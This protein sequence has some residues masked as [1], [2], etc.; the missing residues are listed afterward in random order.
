MPASS[1]APPTTAPPDRYFSDGAFRSAQAERLGQCCGVGRARRAGVAVLR[2]DDEILTA[3]QRIDARFAAS[4]RPRYG[5]FT[6]RRQTDASG[7]GEPRLAE[8]EHMLA[9]QLADGVEHELAEHVPGRVH[10]AY[11]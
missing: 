3:R 11:W 6:A 1:W 9:V 2:H 7:H 8:G 4:C 10:G 5:E